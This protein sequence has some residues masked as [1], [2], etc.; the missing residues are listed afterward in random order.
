MLE[1]LVSYGRAFTIRLNR[2]PLQGV[3]GRAPREWEPHER[4]EKKEPYRR[5]AALRALPATEPRYLCPYR[6]HE[7]LRAR[8]E[9]GLRSQLGK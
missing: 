6:I 2:R 3:L 4:S 1:I 9:A 8:P 7:T 5:D